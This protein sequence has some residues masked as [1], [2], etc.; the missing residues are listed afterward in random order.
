MGGNQISYARVHKEPAREG[1][2]AVYRS[3][4]LKPGS[5]LV[6][7][8]FGTIADVKTLLTSSFENFKEN[9]F[10]GTREKVTE[11]VIDEETKQEK[12]ETKY[13][14]YLYMTY[15]QVEE[16]T[17]GLAKTIIHKN[18]T[19]KTT[20]DGHD[21]RIMGLYSKN[22]EEWALHD[23][24]CVLANIVTVPLYDT[25][26]DTSVEY[27]VEQ[28]E[29][30]TIACGEDKIKHLCRLKKD[31]K[32]DTLTT[33]ISFDEITEEHVSQCKEAGLELY[34]QQKLAEEGEKLE[35]QLESPKPEDVFTLCY[36]S[37]TTGNPKGVMTTHRNITATLGGC[38]LF[39]VLAKEDDVHYSYL[40][41]A[42]V[43]E[44]MVHY[45]FVTGGGRIGYYQGDITK[46][47]EDL[48]VLRPTYFASVP[49]L[50]NRFYDL[51]QAGIKQ[52]TGFKKT[53][54]DWA[55]DAKTSKLD[56]SGSF[57]HMLY[58]KLVFKKFKDILGGRVRI[59]ITGS[60]P[61]SKETMKFLKI[62]FSCEIYEA[63]GQT[64]STGA[65]FATNPYDKDVG[66][67]GGPAPHAE[68]K[69]VDVPEM[70]YHAT[71]EVDGVSQPRGEICIGGHGNFVGYFKESE[72]TKETIDEDGFI[73][74]GDIGII[75]PNGALRIIDRKKNIFKL[76]QGEYIAAE[77]L[78]N[79]FT[80]I[81]LIKQIF[82][83]GDSLQHYLVAIV[84][85]DKDEAIKWAK[86]N[87]TEENFEEIIKDEKFQKQI[88]AELVAKRKEHNLNGL[89]VPKK[90]HYTTTE[91][92]PENDMLTPTFKLKRNEAKKA[93]LDEIKEMYEGAKLQGE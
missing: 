8:M 74:T 23:F 51:M 21:F 17:T 34:H 38:E 36:T 32:I 26:G 64:E 92:T 47:K 45:C 77:K 9:P 35:V 81:D 63:Y 53:L 10:L 87:G 70:D 29:M 37:G 33:I 43:F 69:L 85:P 48:A 86:E 52:Q 18:L 46:I 78:E 83:Y 68:F 13:G 22:R 79:I 91:F 2:T 55:V 67:V 89:E 11:T 56:N 71:D 15:G 16:Y 41:L 65:S 25:L 7:N 54:V 61:I 20:M 66:H 88:E 3:H 75:L 82:V 59:M 24:A 14:R 84:I 50:L 31:G 28:T 72:K 62:A 12:T 57:N 49:R 76:A 60:A 44:R 93:Y 27:I 90:I 39:G 73:H 1:E 19:P 42:H 40:P 58:D 6:S 4:L 30:T 5:D 80:Q